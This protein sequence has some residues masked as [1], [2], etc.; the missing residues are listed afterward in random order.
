MDLAFLHIPMS[1]PMP[2]LPGKILE[3]FLEDVTAAGGILVSAP[4][5]LLI[6]CA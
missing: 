3:Q 6:Y 1:I 4:A 5:T 2:K